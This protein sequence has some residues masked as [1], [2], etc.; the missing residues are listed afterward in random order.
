M[1]AT[2]ALIHLDRF[3]RNID[4][5]RACVG[6]SRICLAVKADA[7]GHGAVEIAKSAVEAGVSQF[8]VATCDEAL[9]LRECG[10]A[11]PILLLNPPVV[12][13]IPTIIERG[14]GCVVADRRLIDAFSDAAKRVGS[15]ARLHL[16]V[17]T[18]MGRIGCSTDRASALGRLIASDRRLRLEGVCTHFAASDTDDEYTREQIRRFDRCIAEIRAVGV[19]PGVVHA[20]NSAGLLRHKAGRYDMVR[21]GIIAYGY[22]PSRAMELSIEVAPVMEFVSKLVF[23]KR[24][25]AGTPISYGMTFRA[26]RET[27]IGTVAAGY[28]DGYNRLLSNRGSVAVRG[29]RYPV[30]GTVCMDQ[31]MIDLGPDPDVSLYDDVV[32]FGPFPPAPDAEEIAGMCGTIAYEITCGIGKRVPR[33]H[34]GD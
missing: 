6:R 31:F 29:K 14:V 17:D 23:I 13:E 28:G 7:Y 24:V 4:S 5:I 1:R 34:L 33:I 22:R 2:R 27:V 11:A 3:I 32:M 26:D 20:A 9:E 19:D 30:V 10:I 8:A 21:P 12:G 15:P 25:P 16:A 18:G